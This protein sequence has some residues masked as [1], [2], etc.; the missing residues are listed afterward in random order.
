MP[1]RRGGNDAGRDPLRRPQVER[2]DA[3]N[4]RREHPAARMLGQTVELRTRDAQMW[5]DRVR[6]WMACNGH[7]VIQVLVRE[8]HVRG[9]RGRVENA[10]ITRFTKLAFAVGHALERVAIHGPVDDE[11]AAGTDDLKGG[12]RHSNIAPESAGLCGEGR[13]LPGTDEFHAHVSR[14]GLRGVGDE[15]CAVGGEIELVI[16][17]GGCGAVEHAVPEHHRQSGEHN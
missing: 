13:R 5:G 9:V 16:A 6:L 12:V 2:M 14:Q 17:L 3:R 11:S 10:L 4:G 15:E 8:H 7:H 1:R